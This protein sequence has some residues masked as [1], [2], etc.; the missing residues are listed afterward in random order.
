MHEQK[1]L[2]L[3]IGLSIAIIIAFQFLFP[4]QTMMPTP[5]IENKED[6]Q[7][8]TSID[9]KQNID[10][11]A[12]KT[13]EEVLATNDRVT[14]NTLSLKGSI[15]LKGAILDDLVL[16]NYKETLDENSKYINLLSPNNTANPYYIEIGWKTLSNNN[17]NFELPSLDTK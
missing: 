15:N 13:K 11:E 4:Q 1:N 16:L 2:F 10:N 5:S 9:Q 3:A 6:L 14:I 8:T 17:L 7:P 12:I